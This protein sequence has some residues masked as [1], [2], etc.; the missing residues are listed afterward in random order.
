MKQMIISKIYNSTHYT[1]G[2]ERN[3]DMYISFYI[4]IF[5]LRSA[6]DVL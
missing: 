2:Q 6:L 5:S 1:I 3:D 4:D